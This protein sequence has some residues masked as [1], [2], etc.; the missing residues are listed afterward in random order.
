LEKMIEDKKLY[1]ITIL[2][3]TRFEL[4]AFVKSKTVI[5]RDLINVDINKFSSATRIPLKRLIALQRLSN[6]I[7]S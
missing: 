4:E 1:P 3:P 2:G 6:Q 7:I 5:A